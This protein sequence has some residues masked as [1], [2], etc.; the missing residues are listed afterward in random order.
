MRCF[1][2]MADL[3]ALFV[4]CLLVAGGVAQ[5]ADYEIVARSGDVEFR[6]Y[7]SQSVVEAS[8]RDVGDFGQSGNHGFRLLAGYIRGENDTGTDLS[9]TAP[10]LQSSTHLQF[11]LAADPPVDTLPRPTSTSIQ[12][13]PLPQRVVAA[14]RYRGNWSEAR[15]REHARRLL[16][17]LERDDI[18]TLGEPRFARYNPPFVPGFARRNEV[19]VTVTGIPAVTLGAQVAS[20]TP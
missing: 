3:R 16:E 2:V 6:R 15:F 19:L 20:R 4:S 12:L 11:I 10:V 9:V 14:L 8:I 1:N 13:R 17:S 7:P 5:A 18:S